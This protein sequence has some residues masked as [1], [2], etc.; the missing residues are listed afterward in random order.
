MDKKSSKVLL[1][2]FLAGIFMG[3]LDTAIISPARTVMGNTLHI[4]ADASIWIITLYS[5]IY[6]VSMPIIG[7][8]ADRNGLK[9]MFTISVLI[10]GIGSFLCGI[11]NYYSSYEFL[12]IAR[13][14]EAIGAGGILPIATAFIGDSFPPEKRGAALGMVGGINGI[15]T[16][17]GPSLG[18]FILDT[19]GAD[20]WGILFFINIPI[21]LV[22]LIALIRIKIPKVQR[23]KKKMD[24]AGSVA[25][26]LFII[27]LMLFITNLNFI[28]LGESFKSIECYPYLIAAI[29]LFPI[30][31]FV[32]S[33]AEDPIINLKYFKNRQMVAVFIIA[34]LV[35]ASLMVVVFL[36]QFCSNVLK[37]KLGS[38]GYFVTLMAVFSGFAAPFGGRLIDKMSAKIV[39]LFGFVCSLIG[40]LILGFIVTST[41][42][43][44]A[45][46]I[47]LALLGLGV[48]FTMGTPLNYVVQSSVP[49]EEVG[50]AQ[51]TLSLIRSL[52]IAL[53]PNLLVGFIVEAGTKVPGKI[54]PLLPKAHGMALSMNAGAG[55]SSM[56]NAFQNANV[57]TI[58]SIIKKFVNQQFTAM[59]PKIEAGVKG[60]LGPNMSPA[61]AVD[62]MKNTYFLELDKVKSTIESTYQHV[63]NQGFEKMFITLAIIAAIA[64][65]T[66]LFIPNKL[67]KIA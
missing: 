3:S 54:I 2:M 61:A 22:V 11:S 40:L 30:L 41:L 17:I 35:G 59:S 60:H 13:A 37:L 9:S 39:L 27:C 33:K 10:F 43:I 26:G 64:I 36:P 48:G 63:M 32:E 14:I 46:I 62:Q 55:S 56:V 50:S 45:L 24:L 29:I 16:L 23:R 65:I 51:S 57:T 5:L 47:G 53:S 8:L 49:K 18:S 21:C 15:A 7:K 28:H 52:G 42:S 58:F 6:A 31:I 44:V 4:S 67:K 38:G 12:L 1:I 19:W 25:S 66:T 34:F 20:R